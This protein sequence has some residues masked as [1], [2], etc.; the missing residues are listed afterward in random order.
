MA[1]VCFKNNPNKLLQLPGTSIPPP[2]P[3]QFRSNDLSSASN[4]M[5]CRDWFVTCPHQDKEFVF[6]GQDSLFDKELDA[7]RPTR[8]SDN[9]PAIFNCRG[10]EWQI[11]PFGKCRP[12]F[13]YCRGLIPVQFQCKSDYVLQ[14]G[15]CVLGKKNLNSFKKIDLF[16]RKCP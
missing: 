9:C 5:H 16:S 2:F 8:P 1:Q 13:I 7:C 15:K 11:I 12:E 4:G 3:G 6:C 14:K 10:F